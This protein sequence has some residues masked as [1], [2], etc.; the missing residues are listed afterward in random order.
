[1]A[2]DDI[3]DI[4]KI[5]NI[6]P[7]RYP[8][9]LVD[10]ILEIDGYKRIKALKNISVNEPFFPGHFPNKPIMPGVLIVECFAQAAAILGANGLEEGILN[11]NSLFYLVGI[12]NARFRKPSGP[13]DQL[14]VEVE[15]ITMKRNIYKYDAKAYI[16]SKLV[17]SAELLTTVMD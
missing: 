17:A 5:K 7:H 3:F 6:L 10:R 14:I 11:E 1:M 16:D 4:E 9:L 13:G 15:F 12:D 2:Q 8:F